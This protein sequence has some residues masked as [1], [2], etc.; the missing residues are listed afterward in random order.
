MIPY[1]IRMVVRKSVRREVRL[2]P[3]HDRR[4]EEQLTRRDLTFSA[5][6]REQ[7]DRD[8][9]AQERTRRLNAVEALASMNIDFG[10]DP[11]EADPATKL[12][13]ESRDESVMAQ[14]IN[15]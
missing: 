9:E 2:D 1:T 6:L 10:W 8:A 15:D 5:W 12:L 11:S 7:I 13:R 4:L 14:F 3:E